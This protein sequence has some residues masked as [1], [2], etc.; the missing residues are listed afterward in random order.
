MKNIF[1]LL[2]IIVFMSCSEK[3]Y[4]V[5]KLGVVPVTETTLGVFKS[6]YPG[7]MFL[8]TNKNGEKKVKI[9]IIYPSGN[10]REEFYSYEYIKKLAKMSK[11]ILGDL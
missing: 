5:K 9:S 3:W 11:I 1:I 10:T 6:T 2:L 4:E 8:V 7:E